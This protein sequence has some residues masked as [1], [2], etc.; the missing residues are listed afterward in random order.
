MSEIDLEENL[1]EPILDYSNII[2][3]IVETFQNS[4]EINQSASLL[5]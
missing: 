2:N 3:S 4:N 1:N 5:E